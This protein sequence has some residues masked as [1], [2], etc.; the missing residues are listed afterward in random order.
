M[1]ALFD[2][3]SHYM[4]RERGVSPNTM[5]G[6]REAYCCFVKWFQSDAG[7]EVTLADWTP[8]N[9]AAFHTAEKARGIRQSTRRSRIA[10]LRSFANWLE[11]NGHADNPWLKVKTPVN[12][13]LRQPCPTTNEVRALFE[14]CD[15][16]TPVR[17]KRMKATMALLALA[18]LR[19]CEMIAVK[20]EDVKLTGSRRYVEVPNGKGRKRRTVPLNALACTLL[21][22]WIAVRPPS[23]IPNL[24][25]QCGETRG[26]RPL[27]GACLFTMF[28]TVKRLA[29]LSDADIT[30]HALR[31]FGATA[32]AQQEGGS[33]TDAQVFLGHTSANTTLRYIRPSND[34]AGLVEGILANP[35]LPPPSPPAA[36]PTALDSVPPAVVVRAPDNRVRPDQA[37]RRPAWRRTA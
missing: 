28:R 16:M 32:L 17:G 37:L 21:A 15:R 22:D 35:V 11:E 12:E 5:V 24:L 8:A 34:L 30:A 13:E 33:I 31:R 6:Y 4:T 3:Y 9:A 7:R 18:G 20:V 10:A 27:T 14:A 2:R 25:V 36:P 19:L 29:M 1:Q 26:H 23:D